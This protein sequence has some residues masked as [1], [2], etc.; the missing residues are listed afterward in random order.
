MRRAS[1]YLADQERGSVIFPNCLVACFFYLTACLHRILAPALCTFIFLIAI[2]NSYSQNDMETKSSV[3]AMNAGIVS[4]AE[5]PSDAP[6]KAQTTSTM[7]WWIWPLLLFV[8]CFLLGIVAVI[9]G[10]GGGV[11]FVPIVGSFFPFHMDYVRATGLLLALS[12][13]LASGPTLLRS[14]MANLRLALP[15]GLVASFSS[16]LGAM[17]GLML[18]ANLIQISLGL[19]ILLIVVI[20]LCAKKSEY[21]EVKEQDSLSAALKMNG[22]YFEQSSGTE[23]NWKV[24]RTPLG[25]FLFFFIGWIAGIYGMGAGWASV[26][27]LNQVMGAPLKISVASSSFILSIVSPPTVW[28]Y[29]N[30]GALIPMI[31]VPSVIGMML[32]ARI[33]VGLLKKIRAENVRKIVIVLLLVASIRAILKGFG[34]WN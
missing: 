7:P 5:T 34:I 17:L 6:I 1:F 27:V 25:L 12:G 15:L 8:T 18:P 24:H 20:M 28:V 29:I 33:G 21:P 32:G 13:S 9:G 11:L 19:V 14:G 3:S 26:P 4:G 22:I 30:R 2:H 31:A 10:V 16:I 23:V